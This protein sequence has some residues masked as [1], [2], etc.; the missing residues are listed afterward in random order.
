MKE[1]KQTLY[2][3]IAGI[4]FCVLIFMAGNIFASNRIA[5]SLGLLLGSV[6]SGIMSA[7]MYR[8]LEQAMLYDENTAAKKV[9]KGTILRF[10]LMVAGLVAALL[11]PEWISVIGVALGVLSLKFSAYL[12]P[13]T[14]KVFQNFINKG[15]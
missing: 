15:R 11:L 14:H 1:T 3:L 7:H 4:I 9:Q 2:E 12:Q 10:L 6:I 5:Y 13:L 8:A